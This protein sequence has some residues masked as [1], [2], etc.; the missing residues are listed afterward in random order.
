M[1]WR[2]LISASGLAAAV[3]LAGCGVSAARGPGSAGRP[4]AFAVSLATAVAGHGASFAVVRMAGA[5][6]EQDLFWQL[7]TQLAGRDRWRLATPPGVADNGGL[8]VAGTTGTALTAGFVPSQLLRFTPLAIT[9]NGGARWSQGLLPALLAAVPGALAALP[10]GRLLAVTR[11]SAQLSAP[12]GTSWSTLVTERALAASPAGRGCGLTALT[13]A[14]ADQAGAPVLAGNC[15]RPGRAGIFSLA[16]GGWLATGPALPAALAGQRIAVLRLAPDA[17]GA[18]LTAGTGRHQVL[19]P[20]WLTGH[21]AA[22]TLGGPVNLHGHRVESVSVGAAGRWGVVLSG[23]VGEILGPGAAGT[24]PR[25][26][27]PLPASTAI[28]LPA[29][30]RVTAFAPGDSSVTVWQLTGA[31]WR[32]AQLIA[33]PVTSGSPGH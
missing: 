10:G 22:W 9:T 21:P 24:A 33:V 17:A 27:F 26:M 18:L 7:L 19:I 1:T 20:A 13:A 28:L 6:G 2:R 5:G 23:Q 25:A 11:R 15:T 32:K 12:P 3:A 14:A 8:V 29:Q 31:G 16:A 30:R 4:P